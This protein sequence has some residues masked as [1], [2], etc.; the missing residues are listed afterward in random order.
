MLLLTSPKILIAPDTET[1][2]SGAP[3][4]IQLDRILDQLL[5]AAGH[6]AFVRSA[7]RGTTTNVV[8]EP[9][10]PVCQRTTN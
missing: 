6:S 8:T 9:A 4:R 3:I 7:S 2:T 1:E 10:L 5:L